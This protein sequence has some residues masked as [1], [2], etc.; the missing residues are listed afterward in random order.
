MVNTVTT[1]VN[2]LETIENLVP[3]LQDL[4]LSH[5]KRGILPEHYPVV[6][7]ALIN[8]LRAGLK[9]QFTVRVK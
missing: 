9:K 3:V 7:K 6:G 8:T 2:G 1:A 5:A 4:G